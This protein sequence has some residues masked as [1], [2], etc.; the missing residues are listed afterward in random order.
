MPPRGRVTGYAG[1]GAGSDVID[2][3]ELDARGSELLFANASKGGSG[4]LVP[5]SAHRYVRP[6][7]RGSNRVD[8][9][10]TRGIVG[11]QIGPGRPGWVGRRGVCA[12]PSA[13]RP[14]YAVKSVTHDCHEFDEL[15]LKSVPA[16]RMSSSENAWIVSGRGQ[17]GGLRDWLP[18]LSDEPSRWGTRQ[19]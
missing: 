19:R 13:A 18:Q 11:P 3:A 8:A 10:T 16:E 1:S 15:D 5:D 6:L 17:L 7:V 9:R 2:D 12:R 4:R 14:V